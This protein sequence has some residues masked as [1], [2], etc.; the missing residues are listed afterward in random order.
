MMGS[1]KILAALLL[2]PPMS[3]RAAQENWLP[4]FAACAGRFSAEVEHAWLMQDTRAAQLET[5]RRQFVD[6]VAAVAYPDQADHALHLRID[7]KAAHKRLL[8]I[9]AF[10]TDPERSHWAES[11][12]RYEIAY[13]TGILLEN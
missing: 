9:A 8:S 4:T 6:L 11:R 3:L 13:C 5:K 12:A 7:A 1:W 2:I 10:V